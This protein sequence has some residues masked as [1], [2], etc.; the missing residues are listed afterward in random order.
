MVVSCWGF[1]WYLLAS[2]K[3]LKIIGSR[4]T[5]RLGCS[6][7]VLH[8]WIGIVAKR[9]LDWAFESMDIPCRNVNELQMPSDCCTHLL[10][11]AR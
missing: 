3:I 6:E 8:D 1:Q 7:E 2:N 11:H 4:D 9:N 5:L 10:L